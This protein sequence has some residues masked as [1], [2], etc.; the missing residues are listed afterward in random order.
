ML[1]QLPSPPTPYHLPISRLIR[2]FYT[3]L[4]ICV[5]HFPSLFIPYLSHTLPWLPPPVSRTSSH[6]PPPL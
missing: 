2:L 6:T 1:Q 4:S 5:P 3:P